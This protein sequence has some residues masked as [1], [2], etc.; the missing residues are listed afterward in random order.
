MYLHINLFIN[1]PLTKGS[2]TQNTSCL[3]MYTGR[4]LQGKPGLSGPWCVTYSFTWY[5][6]L[7]SNCRSPSGCACTTGNM[8]KNNRDRDTFRELAVSWERKVMTCSLESAL[9]EGQGA[10]YCPFPFSLIPL[11]ALFS[12]WWL[13]SLCSPKLAGSNPGQLWDAMRNIRRGKQC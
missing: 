13:D 11:P 10:L 12:N 3:G 5:L 9:I 1:K 7:N 2:N 4:N 8:V 6:L